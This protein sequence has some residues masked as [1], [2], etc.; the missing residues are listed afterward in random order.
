MMNGDALEALVLRYASSLA[1]YARQWTTA[2]DDLVQTAFL[3]LVRLPKP[4]DHPG[5]WL[6]ATVRNAAIDAQ[7]RERR[8]QK[9]EAR[10]AERTPLWFEPSELRDGL[11]AEEATHALA[12]LTDDV[13]EIVVAHLWGGLTFEQIAAM[14]GSSAS[15]VYRRYAG[16]L[17]Q[18]RAKLEAPCPVN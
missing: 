15:T 14:L 13:R 12:Q 5:A 8:R 3:K 18:L 17:Q 1:L 10:R 7:R 9:Y 6:Y 4:P 11:D 16:G 2:P